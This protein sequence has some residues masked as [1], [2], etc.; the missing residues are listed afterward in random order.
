MAKYDKVPRK[1]K[2]ALKKAAGKQ[3]QKTPKK[4]VV[5]LANK[6]AQKK[7]RDAATLRRYNQNK[8][9]LES[10]NIPTDIISKSTSIKETKKRAEKY[11]AEQG[12][13]ERQYKQSNLVARKINRLLDAGFTQEEAQKIVGSFWRPVSDKKIAEIIEEKNRPPINENIPLVGKNYL[14]VGVCEIKDGFHVPNTDALTTEQ[15]KD[16]VQDVLKEAR[17]TPDG[18]ASFSAAFQYGRGSKSNMEYRAKVMYE[19]GYNMNAEHLKLSPE[20]YQKITVSNKWSEHDFFGMFYTCITQM[21]NADVLDFNDYL[22]DYC[23]SNGFPFM[24]EFP[25]LDKK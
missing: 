18:S 7:K 22:K 4:E 11:L 1:K 14:Y 2:K 13:S 25:Y 23:I 17:R 10:L 21:K 3:G 5:T 20:R 16:F 24:D 15:L 8:Q 19:R 9:Y 6:E 12:K